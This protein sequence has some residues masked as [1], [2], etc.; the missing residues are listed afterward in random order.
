MENEVKGVKRLKDLVVLVRGGGEQASGVIHRLYQSNFRLCITEIANPMAVRRGVAFCEAIFDR[1]KEVEGIKAVLIKNYDDVYR[2]W[3]KGNIPLVVDPEMEIKNHIKPDVIVD[4]I[5]AKKNIGTGITDA[6]FVIGLGPGF[7]AG[8]DVH[9]VIETNRGHNIGR[10]IWK[11]SAESN[12]GIPGEVGGFTSER[13]LRA[14]ATG[15]LVTIKEIGD[16]VKKGE[17]VGFIENIPFQSGLN[18]VL[19]GLIRPGSMVKDGMKIGDVDPRG[20]REYCFTISDKARAIAGGVLEAILAL[21]N[22]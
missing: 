21:Y 2:V 13:V 14:P 5:L 12:T 6:P 17:T 16:I 4:A 20:K 10:V 15:T 3:E 22:K 11:G 8:I 1:E 9:A 7:T 18:G 19:R